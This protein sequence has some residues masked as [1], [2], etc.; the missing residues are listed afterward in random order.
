MSA[1]FSSGRSLYILWR[2]R[3]GR[4]DRELESQRSAFGAVEVENCKCGRGRHPSLSGRGKGK[5][6]E[7]LWYG[8]NIFLVV[9]KFKVFLGKKSL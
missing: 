3:K 4:R 9:Q 7:Y 5:K 2:K 8:G 6:G 1:R